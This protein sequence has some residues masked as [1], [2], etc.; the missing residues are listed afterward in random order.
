MPNIGLWSINRLLSTA[1]RILEHSWNNQLKELGLTHAGVT[2]LEV[3]SREGTVSQVRV[4]SI[5]GVQA[6]TMGKTLARLESHGHVYRTRNSVDRRSYLL[7]ITPKGKEV[8]AQAKEIDRILASSGE[9]AKPEFRQML[10]RVVHELSQQDGAEAYLSD[11]VEGSGDD[12]TTSDAAESVDS[13]TGPNTAV[14]D[15]I[16]TD[17]LTSDKN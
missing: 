1:A 10:V 15:V 5:V 3:I 8:L 14:L 17:A 12:V 11:G 16:R 6:Q 2:A 4:A 7:G 9:L 13:A